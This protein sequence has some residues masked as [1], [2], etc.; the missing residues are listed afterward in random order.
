MGVLVRFGT[1]VEWIISINEKQMKYIAYYRVSTT[2]QGDSGLG[3]SAQRDGVVAHTK[4]EP[5]LEFTDIQSGSRRSL[6]K[7]S[8]VYKAIDKAMQLKVPLVVYK[9]DRLGRD[10]EFLN[11]CLNKGV[12]LIACD[13]SALGSDAAT[14]RM[15][16]TM[17][18]SFAQYE[19]DKGRQRTAD[20][21]SQKKK[22]GWEGGYLQHKN[23]IMKI[24]REHQLL[25]GISTMK[26]HWDA[27]KDS[28][29]RAIRQF[30]SLGMD[31]KGICKN[32]LEMG[33]K[34]YPYQVKKIEESG[35][36]LVQ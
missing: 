27:E 32:L 20:A 15:M 26:K 1:V 16:L 31:N 17:L 8:E 21:L 18:M 36:I 33:H 5:L 2:Q 12:Q 34:L 23:P 11:Y 4:H 7:R 6:H 10:V 14:N 24:K 3:L 35:K 25:G 22:E 13:F 30:R 29:Y 19:S 9:L 28:I